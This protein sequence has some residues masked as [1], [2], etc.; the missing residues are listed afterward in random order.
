M[1]HARDIAAAKST[2]RILAGPRRLYPMS[3]V[4]SQMNIN[5]FEFFMLVALLITGLA[6]GIAVAPAPGSVASLLPLL[7][8]K[9]WVFNLAIGSL[10][11]IIGGLWR[12]DADKGLLV[13]QF[14][15]GLVGI[16]TAIYGV[17]IMLRFP[18][19]GLFSGL[20][21]LLFALAC[22]VRVLQVQRF[23]KVADLLRRGLLRVH[24]FERSTKASSGGDHDGE[25]DP[26]GAGG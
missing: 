17:A 15:W 16:A 23:F 1:A 25:R 18:T 20:T 26:G 6:Y 13:Y 7:W 11:A 12:R 24:F 10:C 14:G 5:P 3:L 2:N 19:L 4:S 22:I 21:N 9:V 8:V